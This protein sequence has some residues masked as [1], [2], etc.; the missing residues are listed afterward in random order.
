M[1][2][3]E[4]EV[5]PAATKAEAAQAL[6]DFTAAYNK[7]DKAYDPAAG[8]RPGH[9]RAR[10][11]QRRPAEGRAARTSPGGNPNARAAGADRRHVHDPEEGGL[12]ALV[13]R[14]RRRQRTGQRRR[15]PLAA[16]LHPGRRRPSCG[17]SS[18][19]TVL[20]AAEVP[21]V[22]EG[23]GRPGRAGRRR[24]APTLAVAPARAERRVRRRTCRTGSRSIFADGPHT[25]GWRAERRKKR[26]E[27]G[28]SHAV[29]RPAAGPAATSRRSACAPTDGGALVFFTT[30]HYEQQTAA[31][32]RAAR[33][34]RRGRQGA[35]D[36]RGRSSPSPWSSGLQPG[37][38]RSRRRTRPDQAGA[39]S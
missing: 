2:H 20:A 8:R 30:R 35:D 28:A 39:S 19:L 17:R 16:R 36:G 26:G 15:T 22:R 18:Y 33:R 6:K 10:R 5:V 31:K 27:A 37:G 29:H 13:R 11:D 21:G 34:S 38:A 23:R 32:G 24:T 1:V 9:R 7:A 14:R 25:S 4:R 3:G 12:A